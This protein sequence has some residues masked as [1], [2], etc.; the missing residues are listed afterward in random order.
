MVVRKFEQADIKHLLELLN[1]NIPESFAESELKDFEHYLQ[2]EREHYFVLC[3][4]QIVVACGGINFKNTPDQAWLSWDIVHPD[5]QGKGFGGSLVTHRL[6]YLRDHFNI[7]TVWVRTSQLANRFYEKAGFKE[8]NR[9][10][11]FWSTGF[12]LVE[13]QLQLSTK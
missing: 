13:M 1:L 3:V 8:S 5:F 2:F 7:K 6:N 10:K 12:D 11:D 9:I 4:D